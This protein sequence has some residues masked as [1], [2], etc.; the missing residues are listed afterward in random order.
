MQRQNFFRETKA[1]RIY[2]QQT[3]TIRN[4]KRS[5]SDRRKIMPNGNLDPHKGMKN[6]R[7][8]KYMST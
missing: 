7:N 1:E 4:I 3:Y 8:G 5:S 2:S 6:A